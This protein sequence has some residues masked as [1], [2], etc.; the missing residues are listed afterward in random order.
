MLIRENVNNAFVIKEKNESRDL[1][2]RNDITL[3]IVRLAH[4]RLKLKTLPSETLLLWR[5]N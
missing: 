4:A 3:Q 1:I 5:S 2:L